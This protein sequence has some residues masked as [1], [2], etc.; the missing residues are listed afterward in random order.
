MRI[1]VVEDET[2]VIDFIEQGLKEEGYV[3][4]VATDG[5]LALEFAQTY[6]YDLII[7]D[8]LLPKLDGRQV[9]RTLRAR[10]NS[11]PILMLT[12]LDEVEDRVAGLDSGADDYLIKPFAYRELLA[13]IRARTRTYSGD[14]AGA[15][16]LQVADLSLNRLTRVV[17]RGGQEIVLTTKEFSLLEF[18]MLH[19]GQ[20]LSRVQLGEHVWGHDYYNQSNVVDV[21]VGYLRRKIDDGQAR[22]LLHTVRGVGYKL[23]AEG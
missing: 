18:F 2:N 16:E 8:I 19:P 9:A 3:V 23:A 21:Y 12:A 13:R 17:K 20:V 6:P 14:S 22:P 1:L 15:N 11:T 10:G 5:E 4:D 7:L